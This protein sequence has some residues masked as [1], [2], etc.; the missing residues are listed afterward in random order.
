[1]VCADVGVRLRRRFQR[2][3]FIGE[4][5]VRMRRRRSRGTADL[6]DQSGRQRLVRSPCR[7][8]QRAEPTH[9]I[10]RIPGRWG[11]YIAC[12][13]TVLSL[14][15]ATA[16]GQWVVYAAILGL[17]LAWAYSAPPVRLKQ[18]GWWGN[19]AVAICYEG[20]PWFTGA[21]VMAASLPDWRIVVLALLYSLGAH[22]IMTLNDFKSVEGDERMGVLSLPVQ[23]GVKKA[24]EL[25]CVVM[26]APQFVVIGLLFGWSRP[27]HAI[28]VIG[29][30][31]RT[32]RV[33]DPVAQKPS[34]ICVVV[35]RD[36]DDAIRSRH[37]GQRL[38]PAHGR[39]SSAMNP[40]PLGWPG[41]LRL[42]L[43]QTALG[44][45]VVLMTSTINRVM[46]VELALPAFVPGCWSPCIM[47]CRFSGPPGAT[48]R[49]WAAQN[50][51]DRRRH[52]RARARRHGRGDRGRMGLEPAGPGPRPRR[53]VLSSGWRRRR[54][55]GN[56]RFGD[57]GDAR[58][59][60]AA[61]GGGDDRLGHDDIRLRADG[62]AR[63]PLPRSVLQRAIDRGDRDSGGDRI[64]RFML[65]R[66]RRRGA[67]GSEFEAGLCAEPAGRRF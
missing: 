64:R 25:A 18:N 55:G 13:W 26:A 47:A 36:R 10:G 45:I 28:A 65:G 29:S 67:A 54:R 7:R 66:L 52:G 62:A 40:S 14:G 42:G 17:I 30:S 38:R 34:T 5:V 33:D 50:A 2:A 44:A 48:A 43:V 46:V 1:M 16:L 20:L 4:M 31:R 24:V 49:M 61:R 63:R 58:G 59:A 3:A 9:S 39:V 51:V 21:A 32:I 15:L 53:S 23:L 6:R 35:Q 41:I 37:A 19:S 11:F 27:F 56:L 60:P 22:G 8:H 57:A 12:L